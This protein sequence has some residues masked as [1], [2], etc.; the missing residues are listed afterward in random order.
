MPRYRTG[1]H[2]TPVLE[3]PSRDGLSVQ[4]S[5]VDD[6]PPKGLHPVSRSAGEKVPASPTAFFVLGD[7]ERATVHDRV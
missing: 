7:G 1:R 3:F 4:A 6:E 5:R 2:V